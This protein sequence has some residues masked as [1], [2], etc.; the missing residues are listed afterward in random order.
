[1]PSRDVRMGEIMKIDVEKVVTDGLKLV[2]E[3]W[4]DETD[5][6]QK[7]VE[8]ASIINPIF[9]ELDNEAVNQLPDGFARFIGGLIV[10][11]PLTDK[12]ETNLSFLIAETLYQV[13][14][15]IKKQTG[16][17]PLFK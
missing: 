11:N 1:M 6:A 3:I 8:V 14:H 12:L 9:E 15:T 4:N 2:V 5:G 10:D 7:L 17:L 16:E 13:V